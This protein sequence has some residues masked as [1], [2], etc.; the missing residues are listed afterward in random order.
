MLR[1]AESQGVGVDRMYGDML[2]LGH[3]A[4]TIQEQDGSRVLVVLAGERPD[5]AWMDWLAGVRPAVHDDLR[6]LMAL[7]RLVEQWW[8]DAVDL[9]PYL[10]VTEGEAEQVV[11]RLR[12]LSHAGDEVTRDVGGVPA[13]RGRTV[14]GLGSH[15]WAALV[16]L[17]ELAGTP[18]RAPA[19]ADVALGYARHA[20]RISSTELGAIV[21]ASPTNVGTVLR[22]LEEDGVLGPSRENRRGPGFFYRYLG[23]G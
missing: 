13:G 18:R 5:V 11:A 10:Q 4:P 19:R 1:V 15:A 17:G 21:G 8:T 22:A 2:R 12:E 16:A 14:V 9:A 6:L 3:P 23:R 20:G 7:R